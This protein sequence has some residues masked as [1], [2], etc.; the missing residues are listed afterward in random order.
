MTKLLILGAMLAS[1]HSHHHQKHYWGMSTADCTIQ[2]STYRNGA[3]RGTPYIQC[4]ATSSGWRSTPQ[5][6]NPADN[7]YAPPDQSQGT[8]P[9]DY[10][11]VPC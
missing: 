1:F 11:N 9:C 5:Q 6:I 3:W 7:V 8:Q 2:T 4:V 10:E